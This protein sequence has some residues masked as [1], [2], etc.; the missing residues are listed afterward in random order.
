MFDFNQFLEELIENGREAIRC[1]QILAKQVNGYPMP[2]NPDKTLDTKL[3]LLTTR[4]LER[5]CVQ[6][7]EESL[8]VEDIRKH[9]VHHRLIEKP[10]HTFNTLKTYFEIY[11]EDMR[12]SPIEKHP[13][14]QKLACFEPVEYQTPLCCDGFDWTLLLQLAVSSASSEYDLVFNQSILP[15]LAITVTSGE[16]EKAITKTGII[17]DLWEF[18]IIRLYEIY[19]LEHLQM[20]VLISQSPEANMEEDKRH[21]KERITHWLK[22]REEVEAKQS[23]WELLGPSD[24]VLEYIHPEFQF[25]MRVITVPDEN[26][27]EDGLMLPGITINSDGKPAIEVLEIPRNKVDSFV[28]NTNT[29]VN[30]SNIVWLEKKLLFTYSLIWY[31][32]NY[33]P[34][35]VVPDQLPQSQNA[36]LE[37][38]WTIAVS[39]GDKTIFPSGIYTRSGITV[40]IDEEG[41]LIG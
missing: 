41:V 13:F 26:L 4:E 37:M 34:R 28:T 15:D 12:Q 38:C 14:Y 24:N 29:T 18:Q 27:V 40:T 11:G 35:L 1:Q 5:F 3:D 9:P 30:I 6:I 25:R 21:C 16:G 36:G 2:S 10:L 8:S 19:C 32:E 22:I 39:R 33:G 20:T 17:S 23:V 31:D 7:W